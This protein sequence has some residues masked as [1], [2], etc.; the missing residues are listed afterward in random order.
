[1]V[2]PVVGSYPVPNAPWIRGV[3]VVWQG[4]TERFGQITLSNPAIYSH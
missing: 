3:R 2:E 1:M 4:V